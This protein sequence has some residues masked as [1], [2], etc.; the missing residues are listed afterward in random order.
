MY[1]DMYVCVY[2][3]YVYV[4]A[5]NDMHMLKYV[6]GPYRKAIGTRVES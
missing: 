6:Y 3:E 5:H 1:I 2:I 4:Y